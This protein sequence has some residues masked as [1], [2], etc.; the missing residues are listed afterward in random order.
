MKNKKY[1]QV[2]LRKFGGMLIFSY[3]ARMYNKTS[4]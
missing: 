2:I 1:F 3:I 4:R